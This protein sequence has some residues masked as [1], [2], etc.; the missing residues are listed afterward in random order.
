MRCFQPPFKFI[1]YLKS[2]LLG[3]SNSSKICLPELFGFVGVI[4]AIENR[5]LN[6][7]ALTPVP[8]ELDQ[9]RTAA[10]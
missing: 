10:L 3:H 9:A 7:S 5:E 6:F 4:T 8:D 2:L 1:T